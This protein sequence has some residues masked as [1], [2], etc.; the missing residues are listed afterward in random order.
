[1][2]RAK[3]LKNKPSKSCDAKKSAVKHFQNI[4]QPLNIIQ[5][6]NSR[7]RIYKV[8]YHG[9]LGNQQEF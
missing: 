4:M 6:S 1:M 8:L 2:N 3:N 5:Y 9:E 7:L